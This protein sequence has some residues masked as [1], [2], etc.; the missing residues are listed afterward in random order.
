ML[1]ATP[2]AAQAPC[3]AGTI[4]DYWRDLRI[5]RGTCALGDLTLDYAT[6]HQSRFANIAGFDHPSVMPMTPVVGTLGPYRFAG[7][8]FAGFHTVIPED[9]GTADIGYDFGIHAAQDPRIVVH[10]VAVISLTISANVT[11]GVAP[12]L[13]TLQAAGARILWAEPMTASA[14]LGYVFHVAAS[15]DET[16]SAASQVLT[17]GAPDPCLLPATNFLDFN[18]NGGAA[19]RTSLVVYEDASGV[20]RDAVV[21]A[22][23]SFVASPMEI[24]WVYSVLPEPATLGLTAGGLLALAC[25][26]RGRV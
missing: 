4:I 20:L 14:E 3:A 2:A 5:N 15:A 8:R 13:A 1:G 16:T 21:P 18:A 25:A 24:G 10:H 26:L 17:C 11:N 19:W 22:T 12:T 7:F 23:A 9:Y 6:T